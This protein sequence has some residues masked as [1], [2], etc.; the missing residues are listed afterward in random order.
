[1]RASIHRRTHVAAAVSS[2]EPELVGVDR[3][4][5]ANRVQPGDLEAL[6]GLVALDVF[7]GGK[8]DPPLLGH[9]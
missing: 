5:G 2:Y 1:M 8:P 6:E 4:I 3:G 7:V 9:R